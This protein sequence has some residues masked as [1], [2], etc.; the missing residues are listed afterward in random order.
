M[1]T[2]EQHRLAGTC[3]RLTQDIAVHIP[4][5]NTGI[6]TRDDALETLRRASPLWRDK[7][8]LWQSVKG[9]GP[10]CAHTVLLARPALGTLTRQQSA[11]FGGVVPLHGDRGI[12]RGRRT[13]WGGRTPVRPVLYM[14]TRG[15]DSFQPTAQSLVSPASRGRESQ[16]SRPD[17]V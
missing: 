14:G 6:A 4:W 7:D 13:S 2:A 3:A 1:Q 15:G 16:K 5:R 10:G 11:A 8:A 9:M 12:L 17:G